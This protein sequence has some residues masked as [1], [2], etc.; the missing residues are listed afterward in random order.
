MKVD[1]SGQRLYKK[2]K[3]MIDKGNIIDGIFF[4]NK[5]VKKGYAP[6]QFFAGTLQR[7]QAKTS[8][9]YEKDIA[10]AMNLIELAAKQ[11]HTPA[12][13]FLGKMYEEGTDVEKDFEKAF[14][15]IGLAAELGHIKS[16][17]TFG[18][19][20]MRGFGIKKSYLKALHWL[21]LA[22]EQGDM[23]AQNNLAN[24]FKDGAGVEQDLSKALYWMEKAAKQGLAPAQSSMGFFYFY[25]EAINKNYN[26][27]FSWFE[28]AANQG[29]VHAQG[30]LGYLFV[31]G[32]GIEKNIG[33]GIH[34]STLASNNGD[35][36][37]KT[38]LGLAYL[39]GKIV[40]ENKSLGIDLLQQ[41]A[42][43]GNV[44]AMFNLGV[45][46]SSGWGVDE[47]YD[48]GLG[49]LTQAAENND[50]NAQH[51]LGQ[52][53]AIG[54]M[55]IEPDQ[56]LAIHWLHCSINQGLEEA[57]ET[58]NKLLNKDTNIVRID[59]PESG[60]DIALNS[61]IQA[62]ELSSK[63][64]QKAFLN[65]INYSVHVFEKSI[66]EILKNDEDQRI[67]FKETFSVATKVD[68]DGLSVKK[69][70]IRYIALQEIAGFL[71]TNDGVLIIGISDG[72]NTPSGLP[73]IKGIE[74]D[75]FNGDK[76]KYARTI[77]DLVKS[78]FGET[79][80]SL[81][82]ISFET[83]DLKTICRIHCKKS[84]RPVYCS[85][86]NYQDKPF[87]RY[88]SSTIEPPQREW[89]RWVDQKFS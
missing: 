30:Q 63:E 51:V 56:E 89:L 10:E 52:I 29:Y 59:K 79:T 32:I 38:N 46:Y 49:Y 20:Y 50:P 39:Q 1:K 27:A 65:H 64:Q 54:W 44:I 19:Y 31:N 15:W 73:E 26:K 78:S 66:N 88:G 14:Y 77:L 28:K 48:I 34:W 13:Y 61:M 72:K 68:K 81:V 2:S 25:G 67:E 36:K 69:E 60:I 9:N 35:L 33:K 55:D 6:A 75:N 23:Y 40:E 82:E 83:I 71:N 62:Y 58:L 74:A 16:Q 53:Y 18:T 87:I 21:S 84:N 76:D 45:F 86:K 24:I 12:L 4:L 70:K 11:E 43:A 8:K 5:A 42:K 41:A 3:L 17:A 22:A 85:Y 37:S 57:Q 47:N 80:T 7:H